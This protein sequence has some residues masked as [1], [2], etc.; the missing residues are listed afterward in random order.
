MGVPIHSVKNLSVD[1]L[2][3]NVKVIKTNSILD[4]SE[5]PF[6]FVQSRDC[7]KCCTYEKCLLQCA[8]QPIKFVPSVMNHRISTENECNVF[9]Q[10]FGCS[11]KQ[12]VINYS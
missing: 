3:I 10:E 2:F 5:T 11:V 12:T 4:V 9:A 7:K 8:L 6:I 1:N